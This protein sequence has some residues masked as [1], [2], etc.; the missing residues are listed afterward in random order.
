[1]ESAVAVSYRL[2]R[3]DCKRHI[4]RMNL[5]DKL[6]FFLITGV[7]LKDKALIAEAIL[8]ER[9]DLKWIV[10]SGE[11]APEPRFFFFFH[12]P[13]HLDHINLKAWLLSGEGQVLGVG[14]GG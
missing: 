4:H 11:H 13:P 3:V 6:F 1:M 7:L 12:V 9:N 14:I 5:T 8:L 10:S 2:F